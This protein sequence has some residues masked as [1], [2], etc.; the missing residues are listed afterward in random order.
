M[1]DRWMAAYHSSGIAARLKLSALVQKELVCGFLDHPCWHQAE[2]LHIC[3]NERVFA[4]EIYHAGNPLRIKMHGVHRVGSKDRVSH[5]A[6]DTQPLCD[7]TVRLLKS[8]WCSPAS[9]RNSLP[10]LSKFR[11]FELIFKLRLTSQHDLQQLFGGSLQ[12]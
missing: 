4:E 6:A 8:E 11:S 9:E 1:H 5:G 7:V 10:E 3:V 2:M 12:I